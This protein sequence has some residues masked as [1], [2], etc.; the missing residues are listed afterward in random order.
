MQVLCAATKR[1][2]RT[3]TRSS[4]R[5]SVGSMLRVVLVAASLLGLLAVSARAQAPPPLRLAAA[6]DCQR[7]PNCAPGFRRTYHIDPS[8]SLVRLKVA[9]AGV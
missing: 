9:D 6:S 2:A 5:E 4:R 3:L 1:P 8:R 7:N